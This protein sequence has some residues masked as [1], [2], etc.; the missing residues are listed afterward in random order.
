MYDENDGSWRN[1]YYFI[2]KAIDNDNEISFKEFYNAP[3]TQKYLQK[4]FHNLGPDITKER[5]MG[6]FKEIKKKIC[7]V[8]DECLEE[9]ELV[10][11]SLRDQLKRQKRAEESY[12]QKVLRVVAKQK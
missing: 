3:A 10:T 2:W 4:Q 5:F 6:M 11:E 12:E 7:G 8:D 1:I 9:D